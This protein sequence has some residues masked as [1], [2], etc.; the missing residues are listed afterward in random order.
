MGRGDLTVNQITDFVLKLQYVFLIVVISETVMSTD[1]KTQKE[2]YTR[3]SADFFFFFFFFWFNLFFVFIFFIYLFIFFLL[4]K[5]QLHNSCTRL[6]HLHEARNVL[7]DLSACVCVRAYVYKG[8]CNIND[9]GAGRSGR[10]ITAKSDAKIVWFEPQHDKTNKIAV[11]LAN[12]DK[13]AHP[14]SL[15]S[16]RSVLLDSFLDWTYW[17]KS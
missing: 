3:R 4:S 9:T 7:E 1:H 15:V 6:L 14:H 17:S 12:T 13:P 5:C 2:S 10:V 16:L 8:C 11:R